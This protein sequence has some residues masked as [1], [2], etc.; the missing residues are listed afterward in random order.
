MFPIV[1][2]VAQ[3]S[4]APVPV[5]KAYQK[6]TAQE[7]NA[8]MTTAELPKDARRI[9]VSA[10]IRS[11]SFGHKTWLIVAADGKQ[12]WVENGPSTNVPGGLYGPFAVEGEG[13]GAPPSTPP[14][15]D[16]R[17]PPTTK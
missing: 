1:V 12:F 7:I 9:D 4:A 3:L 16:S 6:L 13:G 10:R 5:Q 14:P 17:W 8:K 11:V 15:G 2:L